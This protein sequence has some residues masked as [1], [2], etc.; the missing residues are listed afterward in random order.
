MEFVY[1]IAEGCMP[2]LH[3]IQ[4]LRTPILDSFFSVITHLGEETFF[5]GIAI[6][7]FWCLNKREGYFI[8][9]TGLI[10]AVTNQFAKILFRIPRP[11]VLDPEFEIVESARAE[12]TGYSFPSGHTQNISSTYGS[13]AAYKPKWWKTILCVSIIGLVS[14]SRMYLGVHTSLDV[15]VSLLVSLFLVLILA[16]CFKTEERMRRSMPWIIIVSNLIAFGFLAYVTSISG[17][18]GID[19]DNYH[20]AMNNAY[21]LLGCT[22]A[23]APVYI[24]DSTVVKFDTEARWFAQLLKLGIGLGI[25]LGIKTLLKE[26]LI[27]LIGN[28]YIA[29]AVR[30]FLMVFFA[31]GIW[32]ITFRWFKK[33]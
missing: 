4:D 26:P 5:L 15:G 9:V 18:E 2:I 3:F 23:L 30:Y 33:L 7:F 28:E 8:L 17:T 11:W 27:S 14:F 6:L 31:G 10:G 12:A 19:P 22:I 29:R 16:P 25:V 24:L 20:N 21:A 1:K 13:I 32:P